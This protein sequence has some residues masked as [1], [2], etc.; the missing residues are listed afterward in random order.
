MWIK[1]YEIGEIELLIVSVLHCDFS[2]VDYII[3]YD[4]VLQKQ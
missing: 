2:F 4:S 3:A 1:E